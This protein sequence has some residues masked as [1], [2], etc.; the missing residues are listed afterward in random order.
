MKYIVLWNYYDSSPLIVE[1]K[2]HKE[3][4]LSV[5]KCDGTYCELF[6]KCLVGME[7]LNDMVKL[8]DHFSDDEIKSI[9]QLG[10][11]LYEYSH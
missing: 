3:L 8:Y 11:T 9:Y 7:T 5:A 6:E 2:D 4:I 1:A 10:D